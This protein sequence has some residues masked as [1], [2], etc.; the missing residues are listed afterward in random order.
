MKRDWN[1]WRLAA[2]TLA[3]LALGGCAAADHRTEAEKRAEAEQ[4]L[5]RETESREFDA[6]LV[7]AIRDSA[8]KNG[9]IAQHTIY[10]YH[11]VSDSAKLNELGV[12]EV[13]VLAEHYR[14]AESQGATLNVRRSGAGDALY[15]ARVR[16]V[17][18]QLAHAG[19]TSAMVKVGDESA[20]GDGMNSERV[21]TAIQRDRLNQSY[22]DSSGGTASQTTEQSNSPTSEP[23][24]SSR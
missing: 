10:P 20:G 13:N 14:E 18:D 23:P 16:S 22:E 17:T 6:G 19:I 1:N 4:A 5:A 12:R 3:A 7:S 21:M 2:A 8:I 15:D 9:I 24:A 11:F